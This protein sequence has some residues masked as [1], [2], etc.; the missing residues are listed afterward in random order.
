MNKEELV[1]AVAFETGE[2][3]A[4]VSRVL[5]GLTKVIPNTLK[6][7]DT[8][9]LV[10]FGTFKTLNK[11]ARAGRNPRTGETLQIAAKV[12]PKFVPGKTFRE[13]V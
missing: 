8:V 3:K 5:E 12:T 1:A 6:Q 7:G 10:G 9:T 11:A 4:A 13:T 2:T